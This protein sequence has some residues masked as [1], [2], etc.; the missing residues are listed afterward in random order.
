MI[1]SE[2][3]GCTGWNI[4]VKTVDGGDMMAPC[5]KTSKSALLGVAKA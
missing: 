3:E 1:G 5:L 2:A 4:L